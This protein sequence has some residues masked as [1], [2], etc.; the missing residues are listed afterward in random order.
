MVIQKFEN[1]TIC[2]YGLIP[3]NHTKELTNLTFL[4]LNK[5]SIKKD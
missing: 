4:N 3:L 1:C 5:N 2:M